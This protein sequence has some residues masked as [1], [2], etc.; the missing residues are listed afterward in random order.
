M[1]GETYKTHSAT[2]AE[3]LWARVV[4]AA[5]A[6]G[7]TSSTILSRILEL[8]TVQQYLTDQGASE[9]PKG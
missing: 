1:P 4:E 9:P 6:Q 5:N 3:S 8:P 2:V 7:V